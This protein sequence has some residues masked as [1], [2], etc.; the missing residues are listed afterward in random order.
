MREA[1]GENTEKVSEMSEIDPIDLLQQQADEAIRIASRT[2]LFNFAM[3]IHPDMAVK[4]HFQTYYEILNLFATTDWLNRLIVSMPP[5]HGKSQG[6]TRML[7]P[8]MLGLNP[9][10]KIA[11]G[12]YAA[13]IAQDF[14]R[15]I[16]RVIDSDRYQELFPDTF[17]HG[18]KPGFTKAFTRNMTTI[19]MAGHRG[20]LRTVGRAGSLT[21]KTVDVMIMD[22]LYKD[23]E[24]ANS[25]VI[26]DKTWR[27]YTKV[28]VPR[29]HNA[30]K[31]LIVFT[32][33][34]EDDL[35][36]RIEKTEKVVEVSSVAEILAVPRNAWIK[37]NFP[38]I[39]D[40]PATELDPRQIGEPLWPE[41]HSLERL[42]TERRRDPHGFNCL[43][44]GE[45]TD[46]AGMLYG[47]NWN[48][49]DEIPETYGNHNY[50]DLA[51][52][53]TDRTLSV[54]YRVGEIEQIDGIKARRI[55]ITDLEFIADDLNEAEILIPMLLKRSDT[56]LC[57]IESNNGGRYF[58]TKVAQRSPG[59][60]VDAVPQTQNKESRILTNAPTVK[61][62]IY[63]PRNWATRW[64]EVYAE[65]TGFKRMFKANA[66]D[67]VPDVFTA[68]IEHEIQRAGY[69]VRRRN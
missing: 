54:S 4:R 52:T 55:Y 61:A 39:Q 16:Q 69:G 68:I 58:S 13:G 67:E 28:V 41:R 9:D 5:Q 12:S 6:S 2:N 42:Q 34:H 64:P 43:Y 66:H 51:D 8:F 57:R 37:L 44:Q 56:R 35:I 14:N 65:A 11:I 62:C 33:W 30:A 29:L 27:W 45:P 31:Q 38:A 47:T 19:E 53:G 36:G 20:W 46:E 40:R 1:H 26:R 48:T 23:D 25:P 49:Y 10:L 18:T 7:P 60:R 22:D 59:I 50:T 24:E 63:L 32:R 15:D 21:S 3:Y 17:L